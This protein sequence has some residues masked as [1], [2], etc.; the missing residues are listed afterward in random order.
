MNRK[1]LVRLTTISLFLASFTAF[2]QSTT[3]INT[4]AEWILELL[5]GTLARTS[6]TIAVTVLGYMAFTGRMDL[7]RVVWIVIGIAIVF[8]G[9]TIVD[10]LGG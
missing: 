6:A 10:S 4:G 2:G 1:I 5:T 8:G 7:G 9:S 3:A